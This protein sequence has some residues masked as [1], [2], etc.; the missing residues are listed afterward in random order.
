MEQY[1]QS[2]REQIF[3]SVGVLIYVFEVTSRDWEKDLKYYEDCL[4]AL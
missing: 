2:Q 1:F 3:T 4:K